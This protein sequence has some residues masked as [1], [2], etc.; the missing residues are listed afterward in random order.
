MLTIDHIFNIFAPGYETPQFFFADLCI[1]I[2]G[3]VRLGSEQAR[4]VY[5]WMEYA[6]EIL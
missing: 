1:K 6:T 2:A 5:R 4:N 3:I